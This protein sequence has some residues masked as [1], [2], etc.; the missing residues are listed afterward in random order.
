MEKIVSFET[1]GHIRIRGVISQKILTF[2]ASEIKNYN[3][4]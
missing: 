4:M 3:A 1:S 2:T